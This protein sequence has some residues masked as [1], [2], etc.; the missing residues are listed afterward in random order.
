MLVIE[1]G[2]LCRAREKAKVH[3]KYRFVTEVVDGAFAK[4]KV[5]CVKFNDG[6]EIIGEETFDS[7]CA[8]RIKASVKFKDSDGLK[9]SNVEFI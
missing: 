3:W 4:A 7:D 1:N 8:I 9:G 6:A 2:V 5:Q